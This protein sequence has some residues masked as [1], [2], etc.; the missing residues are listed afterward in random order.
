MKKT[1][2]STLTPLSQH[3]D[4]VEGQEIRFKLPILQAGPK[5]RQP[6]LQIWMARFFQEQMC[7]H[8]EVDRL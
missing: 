4:A 6:C 1:R 5:V 3:L 8:H 7:Q 2:P